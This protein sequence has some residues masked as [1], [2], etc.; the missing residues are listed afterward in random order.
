MDNAHNF[1]EYLT[2]SVYVRI[3]KISYFENLYFY[4]I[5]NFISTAASQKMIVLIFYNT[6]LINFCIKI[7]ILVQCVPLWHGPELEYEQV[8]T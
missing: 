2:V 3:S 6:I 8:K 5:S 7:I 4:T 1:K